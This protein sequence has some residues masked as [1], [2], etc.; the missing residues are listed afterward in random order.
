[1]ARGPTVGVFT[2]SSG[3]VSSGAAR[4]AK[5]VEQF[6]ITTKKKI[7]K[8]FHLSTIRLIDEMQRTRQEGGHLPYKEGYLR[9][10]LVATINAAPPMPDRTK[11]ASSNVYRPKALYAQ[12][13]KA[14]PGD[15]IALS[16]T[17]EYARRLEFGFSGTDSLGRSYNQAPVGWTRLAAQQWKGIVEQTAREVAREKSS[18]VANDN[19]ASLSIAAE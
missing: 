11:G 17:M 9:A 10:S 6:G 1:M 5:Q 4:F 15:R 2:R 14:V 19:S 12:V 8:V 13:R 18:A 3:R 7:T 16:Y